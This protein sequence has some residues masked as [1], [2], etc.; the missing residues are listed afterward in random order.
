MVTR[1]QFLQGAAPP[2]LLGSRP[3]L[4]PAFGRTAG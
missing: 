4:S 2:A 3:G 1:R